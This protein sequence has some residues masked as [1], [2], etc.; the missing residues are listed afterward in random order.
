MRLVKFDI[1]RYV[2]DIECECGGLFKLLKKSIF[3]KNRTYECNNCFKTIKTK[4]DFPQ[5]SAWIR[6]P[7]TK[8][9]IEEDFK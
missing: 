4:Y 1:K 8:K 2:L 9:I 6:K 3:G 7:K 5:L